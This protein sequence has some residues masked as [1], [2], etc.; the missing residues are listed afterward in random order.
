MTNFSHHALLVSTAFPD[1]KSL[2]L[3]ESRDKEAAIVK[4]SPD[5]IYGKTEQ[6]DLLQHSKIIKFSV[7]QL[8]A[9]AAAAVRR[10]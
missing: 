6:H 8:A 2:Q 10:I 5:I 9:A 7:I 1:S 4:S 3:M